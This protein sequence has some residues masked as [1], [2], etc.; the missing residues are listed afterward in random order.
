MFRASGDDIG[1][2]EQEAGY[3]VPEA[4]I[5]T[6]CALAAMHGAQLRF[7]EAMTAF[8]KHGELVR[9]VTSTGGEYWTRKLV[10]ALGMHIAIYSHVRALC[11][12]MY[13]YI[14]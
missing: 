12:N 6:H 7:G 14:D 13:V 8:H 10:L 4:C 9:V 1:V 5:R 11:V 3:L 2:L